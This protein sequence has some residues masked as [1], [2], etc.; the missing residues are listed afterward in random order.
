MDFA[1]LRM[2]WV[3]SVAFVCPS[4][5]ACLR[6]GVCDRGGCPDTTLVRS[7]VH[8]GILYTH[9][10]ISK[11]QKMCL[12]CLGVVS[13]AFSEHV[14]LFLNLLGQFQASRNQC[15]ITLVPLRKTLKALRVLWGYFGGL[16]G[17]ISKDFGELS[18]ALA[19]ARPPLPPSCKW[20]STC[21]KMWTPLP[22]SPLQV[23][24]RQPT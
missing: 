8:F 21:D 22:P 3:L 14:G 7:W 13:G 16:R 12:G 11:F 19:R 1:C 23:N 24:L 18:L 4:L 9:W 15:W 20:K 10:Q 6:C 5:L 2:R 17:G